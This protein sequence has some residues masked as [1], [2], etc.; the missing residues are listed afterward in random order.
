MHITFLTTASYVGNHTRKSH[1]DQFYLTLEDIRHQNYDGMIITGAPVEQMAFE[2]V[3]Y[4]EELTQILEWSTT[5]VTSTLHICWA[6]Q[7]AL[8]YYYG[9]EKYDLPRKRFGIYRHRVMNRRIPLVRG[10]DDLFFAPHSR[11]T[12]VKTEDVRRVPGM[13]ILAESEEAGAFLSMLEDGSR[14]FLFGHPEYDRISL[15]GEYQRDRSKG[16]DIEIPKNYY[17]DDDPDQRPLLLWRA[18]ANALYTNWLNYY[19]YQVTPYDLG[20]ELG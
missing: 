3:R 9:I 15:N 6:A 10:F 11:H 1:L 13:I 7:A 5:H 20:R 4:W 12:E 18:H 8:H 14:I 19:V 2:E 16:L 17:P